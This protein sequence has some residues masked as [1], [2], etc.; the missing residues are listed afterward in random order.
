ML[1]K[2]NWKPDRAEL[3]KFGA[4][5][6]V[7]GVVIGGILLWKGKKLAALWALGTGAFVGIASVIT[8]AAAILIYWAWMGVA[9]VMGTIVSTVLMMV[10]FFGVITPVGILMRWLGRDTLLRRR[11]EQPTYWKDVEP[12]ADKKAYERLF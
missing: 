3:R 11:P 6:C 7:A 2:I 12:T 4:V 5:M 9:F 10:I 8:P 1:V